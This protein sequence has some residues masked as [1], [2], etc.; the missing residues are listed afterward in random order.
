METMKQT[1]IQWIGEIPSDWN[2]KRI[3]YM[4]N[5]KG[6]IGWQGLTS[7][8]YQDEGAY[9]IT[10]VDFADGG[11]D[12]ENCV[13]VPMKRWEEAKD[14]QIQNGDLLITKDGTIGKVAIVSDMPGETSLNSGVLRIM[15][16][17]GYSRRFLY[18]VIKSDEFWNWFNFRNAGNST[19]IHLY[20]GDFAEFLYAFPSYEEQ[21]AIADFLDEHC[22]KLDSII[23]DLE[24][25]IET[26]K[27]YKKSLITEAVTKGLDNNVPMR[28]SGIAWFGRIPMAW[29][30]KKIKYVVD[31]IR[32]VDHYMP[33]DALDNSN[34]VPYIMTG[35]LK[36]TLS[37]ID[38]EMCKQITEN[39]YVRLS[40]KVTPNEGDVIFAR[41]ATIGTV[42]Y[43]DVERKCVI[44]YSCVTIKP[45][46]STLYGKY[47]FYYLK[48]LAFGEE[49][50]KFI[51][52]NTQGNVGIESL[53]QS[54]ITIPS[55]DEQ[56]VISEWLDQKSKIID[57]TISNKE[58]QLN[59][60][61]MHKASLIFEYVTGKKCVKEVQ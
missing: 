60:M 28:D 59:N 45:S 19:I 26:L 17:E 55:L 13:H 47:L 25:Q 53:G 49:V 24:K 54:Y 3:K 5:L 46:K 12:W 38:F 27:A 48:S 16:I 51:N 23:A 34:S 6:R 21:E 31:S 9:L 18:W 20:Q 8:E 14:I 29:K 10:G 32:D 4:A 1:G 7:D 50:K 57:S 56:I 37:S 40:Q 41:Y 58:D 61:R 33:N 39:D 30:I 42:A 35:D 22:S 36:E 11:I 52:I 15:P 43:V 44:S 2:T